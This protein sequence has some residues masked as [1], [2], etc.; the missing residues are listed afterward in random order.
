MKP[1]KIPAIMVQVGQIPKHPRMK[2]KNKDK[3]ITIA[4]KSFIVFP[5]LSEIIIHLRHA[6]SK[7]KTGAKMSR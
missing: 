5:S 2:D 7:D 4:K 1:A 3:P 6:Q